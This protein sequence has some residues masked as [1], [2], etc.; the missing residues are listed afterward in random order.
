MLQLRPL[1]EEIVP[2]QKQL[3]ES[4]SPEAPSFSKAI[5][6]TLEAMRLSQFGVVA[7]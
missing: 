2:I 7:E 5:G 1:D 4:V 6:D 3:G